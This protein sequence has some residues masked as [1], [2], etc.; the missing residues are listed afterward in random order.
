MF[1]GGKGGGDDGATEQ[2]QIRRILYMIFECVPCSSSGCEIM[3]DGGVRVE[4]NKKLS[5]SPFLCRT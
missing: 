1:C 2:S 3:R 4:K 5:R